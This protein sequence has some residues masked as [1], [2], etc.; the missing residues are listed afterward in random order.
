MTVLVVSPTENRR[1]QVTAWLQ[2]TGVRT[3]VLPDASGLAELPEQ[4]APALIVLDAVSL[5]ASQVEGALE[6]AKAKEIPVLGLLSADGLANERLVARLDDFVLDSARPLEVVARARRLVRIHGGEETEAV[7]K[8]GDLAIDTEKYE[9]R[10]A[11]QAKLLTYK[12][13]ELLR[14][15]ASNPGR[16]FTRE[17]LLSR[18]WGYDYFGGTRTVDVHVRRLRSKIEDMHHTFVETIWNVGYKFKTN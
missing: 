1:A 15:L 13:Y 9:V 18:V 11:G 17:E 3:A 6:K 8:A 4:D 10:V 5:S 12:E 14:L 2:E 16:V 7:I